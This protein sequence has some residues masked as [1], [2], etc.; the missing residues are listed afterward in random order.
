MTASA[1]R[2]DWLAA[3]AKALKVD[4]DV[5]LDRLRSTTYDGIVIEPL[6]TAA[7]APEPVERGGRRGGWDVRQVVD[8]TAGAG[9][10]VEELERGAT[11]VLLDLTGLAEIDAD[12]VRAA[13]DGV[14]LDVAPVVLLAGARWREAADAFAPPSGGHG[15]GA[16]PIG[17]A[18]VHPASLDLDD[19]LAALAEW[20]GRDV[21]VRVIT[22]DATRYHDAGASDA[23]QLGCAVAVLVD[24]LRAL[25]E[26]GVEP[27]TVLRRSELRVAATADQ[28]ATIAS[29]RALRRLCARVAEVVGGAR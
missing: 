1:T 4:P 21:D 16:D 14:L 2:D 7:D 9:R 12:G 25:G 8:A 22:V 29:I 5:A 26:R 24:Y 13:L 3:V 28:F 19:H 23:Q 18:A 11:S 6:Y 15:L 27:D 10:A 17:E 20:L